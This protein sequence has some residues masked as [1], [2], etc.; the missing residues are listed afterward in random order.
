MKRLVIDPGHG[1]DDPGAVAKDGT[2][3]ADLALLYSKE[4]AADLAARA[5][6]IETIFTHLG[7][8]CPLADRTRMSN[9]L[10]ADL[11][12]SIHCNAAKNTEARGFEVFTTRGITGADRVATAIYRQAREQ[13]PE[14]FKP[15]SDWEDGDPD[16]EA[17][18]YVL[19]HT[20]ARAVLVEL[21]FVSNPTDL[22]YLKHDG[23]RDRWTRAVSDGI[24]LSI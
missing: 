16:R 11:F 12:V 5:P 8:G 17:N 10:E 6:E 20:K 22:A 23:V 13:L 4:I 9:E 7:A 24:I 15:R 19:R 1:G 21:G 3:E 2:R 14:I 18:F